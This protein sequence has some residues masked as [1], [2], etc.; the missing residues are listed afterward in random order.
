[1]LCAQWTLGR[2]PASKRLP[3]DWLRSSGSATRLVPSYLLAD[4]VR[5][6]SCSVLAVERDLK[7]HTD[8]P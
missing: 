3:N 4:T 2:I 5:A 8:F 1:M 7:I 6:G